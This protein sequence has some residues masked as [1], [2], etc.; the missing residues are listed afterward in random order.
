MVFIARHKR[1]NFCW[2]AV[3]LMQD[4]EDAWLELEDAVDDEEGNII[5][6][7]KKPLS[8]NVEYIGY[9]EWKSYK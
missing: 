3:N 8:N 7:L 1:Q 4:F 5:Y 9:G 6:D 2:A